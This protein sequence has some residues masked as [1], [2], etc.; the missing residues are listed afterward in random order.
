MKYDDKDHHW[1]DGNFRDSGKVGW[2]FVFAIGFLILFFVLL[3]WY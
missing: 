2:F 3:G 1:M